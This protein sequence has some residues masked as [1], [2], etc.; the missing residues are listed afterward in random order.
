MARQQLLP[1]SS[2]GSHCQ[3]VTLASEWPA[4]NLNCV[5]S[6]LVHHNE[7]NCWTQRGCLARKTA[8]S[9]YMQVCAEQALPVLSHL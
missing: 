9:S 3:S 5:Q 4:N 2:A 6:A 7:L 8:G 1:L